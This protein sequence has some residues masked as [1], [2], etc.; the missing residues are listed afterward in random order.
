MQPGGAKRSPWGTEC[1]PCGPECIPFGPECSPI[2]ARMH[3]LWA[4][5]S[6]PLQKRSFP[7]NTEALAKPRVLATGGEPV[8]DSTAN[9]WQIPYKSSGAIPVLGA[10]WRGTNSFG[11]ELTLLVGGSSGVP[12]KSP[13]KAIVDPTCDTKA[14]MG[15]HKRTHFGLYMNP[16]EAI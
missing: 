1:I 10:F 12:R 14:S 16:C 6:S 15:S 9:T 4:R 11:G 3:P 8:K 5:E 13:G 2:W 7:A